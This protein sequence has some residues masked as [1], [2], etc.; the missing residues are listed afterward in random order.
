MTNAK[1]R[2]KLTALVDEAVWLH[3][4]GLAR[5]HGAALSRVI[6]EALI[7]YTTARPLG[8]RTDL[9][10]RLPKRS[11]R[12]SRLDVDADAARREQL[13]KRCGRPMLAQPAMST[14]DEG[15]AA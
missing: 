8:L 4:R 13:R 5:E 10:A 3:V 6:E 15:H 14:P 1:N 11:G 7:E 12:P 9:I 2:H